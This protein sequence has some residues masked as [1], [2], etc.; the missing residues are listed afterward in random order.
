MKQRYLSLLSA[1]HFFTD[2]N[3]G[4]LPAI[5]PF[6]IAEYHLSYAAAASLVFAATCS[7]S[8]VQPLFGHMADRAPRPWLMPAGVLLA[9]L[10]LAFTGFIESYW[11]LFL[12]VTVS[13]IGIAAFHPEAARLANRVSG[14]KK[15]TGVSIFAVG[16]NAGFAAGPV[17]TTAALLLWGMKGTAVLIVPVALMA[18]LLRLQVRNLQQFQPAAA[19]RSAG[20]TALGAPAQDEWGAFARLGVVIFSRSMIF[21]G[22]TTFVPLYWIGIFGHPTPPPGQR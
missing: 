9:G 15:G 12:S 14:E 11:L 16:G 1:G 18:L 21:Y 22:L 19:P 2:V 8:I 17:I 7:S 3:Q 4:A 10:G 6:L 5:L 20:T 13:G